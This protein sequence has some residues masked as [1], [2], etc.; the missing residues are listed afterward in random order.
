M[1]I[2]GT[3]HG[4]SHVTLYWAHRQYKEV[5]VPWEIYCAMFQ[6]HMS[7]TQYLFQRDLESVR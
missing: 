5:T 1:E 7:S 4:T 3:S 2:S 6:L